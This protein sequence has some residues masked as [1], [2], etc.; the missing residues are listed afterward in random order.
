MYLAGM[1]QNKGDIM[2]DNRGEI[3]V[4]AV[5]D[6]NI[7]AYKTTVSKLLAEEF[8]WKAVEEPWQE[9]SFLDLFYQDKKR[10][11]YST[12]W[13]FF[14]IRAI[15]HME[16]QQNT[17]E[18]LLLERSV[19]SDRYVFAKYLADQGYMNER[20][21]KSYCKWFDFLV[22]RLLVKP[23]FIIYLRAEPEVLWE[24]VKQRKREIELQRDGI[25]LEYLRGL[26]KYYDDFLLYDKYNLG[27]PVLV[28]DTN[29][30]FYRDIIE[31]RNELFETFRN[32][33]KEI[34]EK[35]KVSI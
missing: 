14:T 27:I 32:F 33:V 31:H 22:D 34:R 11:A 1:P 19:Y 26:N 23:S 21:W 13:E 35:A 7:G 12:Q 8:G 5:I 9:N 30:K 16:A 24:R 25:T 2:I 3:R 10:W 17:R 20:E 15:R 28:I 18:N 6:G 4:F 29:G